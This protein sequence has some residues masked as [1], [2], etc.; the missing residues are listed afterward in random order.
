LQ[1]SL[2]DTRA[3]FRILTMRES[4]GNRST[5]R[6]ALFVRRVHG[7]GNL[8]ICAY[9]VPK[10]WLKLNRNGIGFIGIKKASVAQM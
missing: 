10:Q 2:G 1:R 9:R 4:G 3:T 6:E 7:I 5:G 8:I